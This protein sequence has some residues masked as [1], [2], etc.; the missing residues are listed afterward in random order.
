MG[1]RVKAAGRV[2]VVESGGSGRVEL[3]AFPWKMAFSGANQV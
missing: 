3:T 2:G 1:S